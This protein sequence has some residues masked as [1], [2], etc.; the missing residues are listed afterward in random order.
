M[1]RSA[2]SRAARGIAPSVAYGVR[3]CPWPH[4]Q[5]TVSLRE[6]VLRAEG[7]KLKSLP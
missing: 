1:L 3:R 5:K 6:L 4:V 2:A 7:E